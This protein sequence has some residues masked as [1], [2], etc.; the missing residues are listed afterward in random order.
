[1]TARRPNRAPATVDGA[2]GNVV[3][4]PRRE[5]VRP[6]PLATLAD[7]RSELGKIY[8]ESRAGRISPSDLTRYC[9]AL[10]QLADLISLVEIETR[11]D[12]LEGGTHESN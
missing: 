11:L 7:V 5:R 1:M 3:S 2:T 10:R 12:R 8:R 9:Y 4:T 6:I